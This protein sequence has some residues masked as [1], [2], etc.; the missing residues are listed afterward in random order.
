MKVKVTVTKKH[1]EDARKKRSIS[2]ITRNCPIARAIRAAMKSNRWEVGLS[3]AWTKGGKLYTDLPAVAQRFV[4]NF[5]SGNVVKPFSFTL[6][7]PAA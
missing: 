7:L 3:S 6:S 2:L 4:Q 5:D 1:I